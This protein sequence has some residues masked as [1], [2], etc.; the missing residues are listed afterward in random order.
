MLD[1]DILQ[2]LQ[3]ILH[4]SYKAAAEFTVNPPFIVWTTFMQSDWII[5]LSISMFKN[6]F[7][8]FLFLCIP[9]TWEI[10]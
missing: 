1:H 7:K 2:P 5:T 6:I 3:I 8:L 9:D 4:S 10:C